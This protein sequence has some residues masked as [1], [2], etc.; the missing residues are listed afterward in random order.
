MACTPNYVD[1]RGHGLTMYK[2]I[3]T[4]GYA[5]AEPD[6]VQNTILSWHSEDDVSYSDR[7]DAVWLLWYARR[8]ITVADKCAHREEQTMLVG[9]VEMM[10]PV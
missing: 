4:Q 7:K 5:E 1:C 10:E 6:S 8:Q 3:R 2:R 9:D